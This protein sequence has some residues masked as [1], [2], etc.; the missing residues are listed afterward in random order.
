MRVLTAFAKVVAVSGAQGESIELF[1]LLDLFEGLRGEG[2]F[3]FEGVED[4]AF[5]K[6]A[7]G[8][9]L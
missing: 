8:E 3:A 4:D 1:E 6:V 7:E 2:G 5:E 9:V